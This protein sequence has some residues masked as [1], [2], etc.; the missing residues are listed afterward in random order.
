MGKILL[1][2]ILEALTGAAVTWLLARY[3]DTGTFAG[4]TATGG[5]MA[6][7]VLVIQTDVRLTLLVF[8]IGL[9]IPFVGAGA[10]ER[11]QGKP[12]SA[13]VKNEPGSGTTVG[14]TTDR[15]KNEA[16]KPDENG[17]T[18]E[19]PGGE[20]TPPGGETEG[21]TGGQDQGQDAGATAGQ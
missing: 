19:G 12:I 13:V 4:L 10:F 3:G 21:Q 8:L 5:L 15:L 14:N 9:V 16:E 11:Q 20:T 7:T 2:W 6:V 17:G 1:S 18:T